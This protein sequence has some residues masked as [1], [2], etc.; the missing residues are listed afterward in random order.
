MSMASLDRARVIISPAHHIYSSYITT[1]H[2]GSS[3]S[4]AALSHVPILT[5]MSGV[6]K[7]GQRNMIKLSR[8]LGGILSRVDASPE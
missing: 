7:A 1:Y 3:D 6:Q 5:N 8:H 4:S 2:V